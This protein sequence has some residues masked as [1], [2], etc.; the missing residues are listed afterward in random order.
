MGV[1]LF[2]YTDVDR[3]GTLTGPN[4]DHYK[5]LVSELTTAKVIASGGVA[6]LADLNHLQE[7][8]VAGTIVGKPTITA[9][10]L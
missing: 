6:E 7:I 9:I 1:T 4:L 5:C 3:D 10:S 2:I 8:G